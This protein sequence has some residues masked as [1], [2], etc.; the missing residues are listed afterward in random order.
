VIPKSEKKIVL[1]VEDDAR[2]RSLMARSLTARGLHVIEAEGAQ[3]GFN[4]AFGLQGAIDLVITD[5]VMPGMS[6]L[7]L[8]S[9]LARIYP[10]IKIL[11]ISGHGTSVAMDAIA[12]RSPEAVLIKPF[13]Q[14]ALADKVEELLSH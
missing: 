5:M 9:V 6:G 3:A 11:Y 1:L 8:A 13:T 14:Q 12:E 2:L 4:L 7:D 10:A